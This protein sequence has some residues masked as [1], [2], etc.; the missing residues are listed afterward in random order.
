MPPYLDSIEDDRTYF[1][2]TARQHGL[3]IHA[4]RA[5]AELIKR[6]NLPAIFRFE[7]SDKK[8]AT[9]L[10]LL[11]I[12]DGM[13]YFGAQESESPVTISYDA[14][15]QKFRG[16]AFVAWKNYLGFEGTIPLNYPKG[17]I[18]M[19]KMLLREIGHQEIEIDTAYNEPTQ[20]IIKDIQ[21]KYGITAD[22][23][24]GP[25]TKIVLYLEKGDLPGPRLVSPTT[26]EMGNKN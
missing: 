20:A 12:H 16:T 9:Y 5:N 15:V 22:G 7:V 26:E 8:P 17:S 23:Y 6:L 11:G 1:N 10:T 13:A 14:L 3:N 24:V 18:V 4:I 25:L 19:L 21:Q 2:L